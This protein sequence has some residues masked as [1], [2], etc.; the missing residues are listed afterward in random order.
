MPC[1]GC[2]DKV[3]HAMPSAFKPRASKVF[4]AGSY[5][6]EASFRGEDFDKAV[7]SKAQP[8]GVD[9]AMVWIVEEAWLAECRRSYPMAPQDGRQDDISH[10]T[11]PMT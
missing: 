11:H 7:R 9:G 6:I 5:A 3:T 2:N 4:L 8:H 10:V 1:Q